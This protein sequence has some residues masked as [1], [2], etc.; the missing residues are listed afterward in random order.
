[1]KFRFSFIYFL[2]C[3]LLKLY[4]FLSSISLNFNDDVLILYSP[5]DFVIESIRIKYFIKLDTLVFL[6]LKRRILYL[7]CKCTNYLKVFQVSVSFFKK[8]SL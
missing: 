1:M 8:L 5:F 7:K 4:G 2:S 3:I 6:F